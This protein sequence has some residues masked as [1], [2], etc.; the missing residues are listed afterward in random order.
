MKPLT[1]NIT[2]LIGSLII[3]T[4]NEN[5]NLEIEKKVNEALT[6]AISGWLDSQEC[7]LDKF[8]KPTINLENQP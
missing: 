8:L 6:K 3:I 2:N 7:N 4:D 1:I 5:I